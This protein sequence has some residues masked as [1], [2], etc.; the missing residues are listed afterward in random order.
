MAE[1]ERRTDLLF[2]RLLWG[3][4]A[5]ALLLSFW[6][7]TFLEAFLIGLP[8]SGL[9]TLLARQRPGSLLVRCMVG[10]G[11]MIY[12]ALY[13]Q[14]SHGL[15]EMHFHVFS[16]LAFLLAYRD[17]RAIVAAAATIAGQ[18]VAFA[19]LQAQH[20]PFYVYSSQGVSPVIL[21]LLHAAFVVFESAI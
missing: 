16:A 6:Y 4:F 17:W 10:I 14:Q 1:A 18:H 3:H 12:S 11:L 21:T 15:T 8:T 7:G 5:V 9:I 20:L 13:I 19:V 2:I